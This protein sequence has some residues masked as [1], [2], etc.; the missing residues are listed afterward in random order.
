MFSRTAI[1]SVVSRTTARAASNVA[2]HGKVDMRLV[3]LG[4]GLIG[5]G[6]LIGS[7]EEPVKVRV[8]SVSSCVSDN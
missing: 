8:L 2:A 3:G 7:Q 6:F 5:A 1:R 4:A